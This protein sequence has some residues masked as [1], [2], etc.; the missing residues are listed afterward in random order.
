MVKRILQL[1]EVQQTREKLLYKEQD[2]Q[3][4]V[5]QVFEK[6]AHKEYFQLG[7]LVLK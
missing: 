7:D 6:S 1:V 3:N 5:K 2:H 4:K